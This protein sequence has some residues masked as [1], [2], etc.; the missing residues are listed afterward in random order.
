[1][2]TNF[3]FKSRLGGQTSCNPSLKAAGLL[4]ALAALILAPGNLRA[5]GTAYYLDVNYPTLGLGSPSGT[6]N[7]GDTW[8][9]TDPTGAT[10]PVALP[11]L[12]QMTFG[13]SPSDF[14]GTA[15]TIN[16]N[17]NAGDWN[18]LLVNSTN[19]NITINGN[20][21]AYLSGAQTWT[22][23]AG[24]TFTD[25]VT[26]GAGGLNFNNVA[27]TLTGG[28]TINFQTALGYNSGS[29]ITE[30]DSGL[31]LTVN[32]WAS[33][34][35]TGTT[36]TNFPFNLVSG[37]LNFAAPVAPNALGTGAF[38]ISGGTIDN[39][40]GGPITLVGLSGITIANSFTFAGS[41]NLNLG[42]SAVTLTGNPVVT[43]NT[44]TLT[45]GGN[46]SGSGSLIKSGPGTLVL[47]GVRSYTGSTTVNAGELISMTGNTASN[48]LVTVNNGATNG[49]QINSGGGQWVC[50][51]LSY[52]AGTAYADFIFN[53]SPSPT[54]AP[55]QVNGNLAFNGTWQVIIRSGAIISPG[56]Y[57]LIKYTNSLSGTPPTTV[58]S[59][60]QFMAAT[61]SNNIA[62]KSIDLVVTSGN[63]LAWGVGSGTW[64]IASTPNWNSPSGSTTYTDGSLVLFDD[65]ASGPSPINVDLEVTVNPGGI[66][67]NPTNYSYTISTISG[68][69]N[70]AGPATLTKNG[71]GTL[72]L[73]LLNSFTGGT[74]VNAGI[75]NL[76]NSGA[77]GNSTAP[78][79]VTG[80]TLDLG[81]T[82]PSF[83]NITLSGGTI[84]NGPISTFSSLTASPPAGSVA[85]LNASFTSAGAVTVNGAGAFSLN[86]DPN[87][88]IYLTGTILDLG[89]LNLT[90]ALETVTTT[91]PAAF[92]VGNNGATGIV[93]Q[94]GATVNL[95]QNYGTYSLL[96][97]NGTAGTASFYN[98][99]G[100]TLT[101]TYGL[102]LGINTGC[103]ATFNMTNGTLN[104]L[105]NLEIGRNYAS[106]ITTTNYFKQ[107]GGTVTANNLY[108]ASNT[109]VVS[110]LSVSNGTFTATNFI[111]MAAAPGTVAQINIGT[112]GVLTVGAFP[113]PNAAVQAAGFVNLTNNGGTLSP[114]ASSGSYMPANT[115]SHFVIGNTN[116]GGGTISVPAGANITIGQAIAEITL[117]K[118]A[119]IKA[120]AGA[121]NLTGSDTYSW[122]TTVQ[123]GTLRLNSPG[124]LQCIY[125]NVGSGATFGGN[126]VVPPYVTVSN[127]A[128]I[129]PGNADNTAGQLRI[130][131]ANTVASKVAFMSGAMLNLD[132]ANN[133][134]AANN[135]LLAIA[136]NTSTVLSNYYPMIVNVN[137]LNGPPTNQPY[138]IITN[139]GNY[140]PSFV[141][142]MVAG[143]SRYTPTFAQVGKAIT[144]TFTNVD[145]QFSRLVWQ[146]DP[147]GNNQWIIGVTNEWIN[148]SNNPSVFYTGDSTLFN[149]TAQINNSYTVNLVGTLSPA[150]V[151]VVANSGSYTF[152]GSGN[153]SGA[154]SLIQGGS[155]PLNLNTT[156]TYTGG[157]I[158][159]NNAGTVVAQV[160]T[161]QDALG[162]GQVSVGT[163]SICELLDTTTTLNAI[164]T[165]ANTFTGPGL[166][167]LNFAA[168]T[169]ARNTYM[170]AATNLIGTIELANSGSTADKWNISS[171]GNYNYLSTL[172]ID[173]GSTIYLPNAGTVTFKGISVQGTGNSESLGAIRMQNASAVLAGPITLLDNTSIGL[174]TAGATISGSIVN[175]TAGPVTLTDGIGAATGVGTLAG[176]LGDGVLGG[177][178]SLTM[179]GSGTLTLA[180]A[181]T[182]S[183]ATTINAGAIQLNN[184]Y[185]LSNS[186]VNVNVFSGL[187]FANGIGSFVVGG[188]AG[189]TGF[190]LQD[191]FGGPITLLVGGNNS[192][193]I[194]TGGIGGIGNLVKLGQGTLNFNGAQGSLTNSGT[195]TV[196]NGTLLVYCATGSNTVTV[197]NNGVLGGGGAGYAINGPVI[198]QSGGT[199]APGTNYTDG[200]LVTVMNL[201]SN[202]VL[203]AGSYTAMVINKGGSPAN[204][205]MIYANNI[206]YGGTLVISN[207]GGALA[208]G[209]SFQIFNAASASGNFSN[210]TPPVTIPGLQWNFAP[211]TGILSV[212]PPPANSTN[213]Y[214]NSLAL[215]PPGLTSLFSSNVFIYTATNA[216][217]STPR[218]TVVNADLTATDKL[219]Y[220]NTTNGLAS[221]VQ[222]SALTLN[223]SPAVTN[224]VK[225]L[226]TAQD[227]VTTSLYTVNV[228][229][230]P[231]TSKPV[232]KSSLGGG[233]LTL[234]WP[235]DHLGYQ[236]QTNS[237]NLAN[238]IDWF[239]Y[240][241]STGT[242]IVVIPINPAQPNVFY[243]LAH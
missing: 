83:G 91:G 184:T 219:I 151:T 189:G 220:N 79:T 92:F 57:P 130:F 176:V 136:G 51:G 93:N 100:G 31:G 226:V 139:V 49:V 154:T 16:M 135:D 125:V 205:Q 88:T 34:I 124:S 14:N 204:P 109:N 140:G 8:W 201:S 157:T 19:A 142:N 81:G 123:Q 43:V 71:S 75:L 113:T 102:G 192:S 209:D 171:T 90:N 214:L 195:I 110:Y 236:L 228:V 166:L 63:Q 134:N 182:F 117:G 6:Y 1:M 72:T 155:Q 191:I 183:G 116:A 9:T 48:G 129:S 21:N 188:I 175:G 187:T 58:Y 156:N 61:I 27:L 203:N 15:F 233:M 70:I 227:G 161:A 165:I 2:K 23:A 146:G 105:A 173:S 41:T 138:T 120:G 169:S 181:N 35:T 208:N 40:S 99:Y 95:G 32:L 232:L 229:Q 131:Y 213:A 101:T 114:I 242:T 67:A 39:T 126:T 128:A 30:A 141:A 12:V 194:Y 7:Q 167:Q 78:L 185:A 168:G 28:G 47:N 240:P 98:L 163:N 164:T 5:N 222:S 207:M 33:S 65:S 108:L 200:S 46:I 186:T 179:A 148:G 80:G 111:A 243:R 106:V 56:Q 190:N 230:L 160:N 143:V 239:P 137:L 241:N 50:A 85:Q 74:V 86:G 68:N 149:D 69:G 238:P 22:V 122:A 112:N 212:G 97:G 4:L 37:N 235:L 55:I 221:G 237:V 73:N 217:G 77:L 20:Q 199:L 197:A 89:T 231:S 121:L 158:I 29:A 11:I 127:G 36:Y 145:P 170:P 94:A 196:S 223:P 159:S 177:T 234:S 193:S 119:L 178:L 162:I 64:D 60:P 153:I 132:L 54:S 150:S 3:L 172:Q 206:N 152:L 144:V 215:N 24:S 211:A 13:A 133:T 76:Q 115:F 147:D 180:S 218:V 45:I 103:S 10:Q 118:G 107:S 66:T 87:G 59:L 52:A 25:D 225:V 174:Q 26:W 38:T 96:M 202:L 210:I 62:N 104:A 224:V 82:G 53:Q 84:Q 44:N 198:V 18:G 42:N 216:Y 17:V